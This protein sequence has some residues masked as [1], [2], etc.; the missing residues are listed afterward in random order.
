MLMDILS[1]GVAGNA[2]GCNQRWHG[3]VD[4][5]TT[6]SRFIRASWD[7]KLR[8]TC[9]PVQKW[10]THLHEHQQQQS[11]GYNSFGE[12]LVCT[13]TTVVT[14]KPDSGFSSGEYMLRK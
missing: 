7:T 6:H 5:L 9:H 10:D 11:N 4:T 13:P 8:K 2:L 14:S 12:N 1:S 3:H